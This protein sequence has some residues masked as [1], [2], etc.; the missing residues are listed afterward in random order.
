M[1]RNKEIHSR[2]PGRG[3]SNLDDLDEAAEPDE[4]CG[5]ARLFAVEGE[6]GPRPTA[7]LGILAIVLPCGS[8]E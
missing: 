8:Y 4:V 5:V 1:T 6:A 3:R 2:P 7:G